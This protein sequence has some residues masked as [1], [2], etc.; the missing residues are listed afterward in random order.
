M[1][2]AGMF[3]TGFSLRLARAEAAVAGGA[4]SATEETLELDLPA[5]TGTG[6][7]HSQHEGD[8]ENPRPA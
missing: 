5:L 8:R 1:V 4:L 6:A 2:S 7:D 3:G